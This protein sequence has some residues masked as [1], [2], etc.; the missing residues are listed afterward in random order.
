MCARGGALCE[1][2]VPGGHTSEL[3]CA[4][5]APGHNV[6]LTD[7]LGEFGSTCQITF[8]SNAKPLSLGGLFS[9]DLVKTTGMQRKHTFPLVA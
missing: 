5:T 3:L 8:K 6:S 2:G 7:K 9:K 4:P 1:E